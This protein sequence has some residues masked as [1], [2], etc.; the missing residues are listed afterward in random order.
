LGLTETDDA[1]L[2]SPD[3]AWAYFLDVD[4][5]LLDLAPSPSAVRVEPGTHDLLHGLHLATGGAVA[6]V[7]GRSLHDL[8]LLFPGAALPAAGQHGLERRDARGVL[9]RHVVPA[10]T[11][12]HARARLRTI[13]ARHAG[14]MLEDK[15]LS[16]ALHYRAAPYLET[17]MLAAVHAIAAGLDA[18]Y[19]VQ[20]G[21]FVVELRPAGADKGAAIESFMNEPPFRG[22][23]PVFIGDDATDEHGFAVVNG[24][25]GH[26][27]KVG[28]GTTIA[29][30]RVRDV[31]AVERWLTRAD[32]IVARS[33]P[34]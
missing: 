11:L 26:S 5:T 27:L 12:A 1:M 17:E 20:P 23:T 4:G 25:R 33:R 8:D 13:A 34:S 6:L 29:R 24:L 10:E 28:E 2:P 16:I 30:W 18:D 9:A 15:G 3:L 21:K 7:S 32:D 14:L 19:V 31:R 22:R